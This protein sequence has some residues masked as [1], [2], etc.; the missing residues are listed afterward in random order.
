MRKQENAWV[1][2]LLERIEAACGKRVPERWGCVLNIS[3]A[4]ATYL[5]LK[6][7]NPLR[8]DALLGDSTDRTSLLPLVALMLCRGQNV[9]LLP[10]GD[11]PLQAGDALLFTGGPGVRAKLLL[12]LQNANALDYLLTGRDSPGGWIWQRWSAQK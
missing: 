5:H 10:D 1:V 7:G 11:T 6:A 4:R 12:T 3:E 2:Y 9:M 8:L